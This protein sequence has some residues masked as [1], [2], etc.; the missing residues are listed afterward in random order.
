M[1]LMFFAAAVTSLDCSKLPDQEMA[2]CEAHIGERADAELN[3]LWPEVLA[4]A[5]AADKSFEPTQRRAQP[6]AAKDLLDAQRA[7]LKYRDAECASE[8]SV[9]Q[10]GSLE[11]IAV[12]QCFTDLTLARIKQLKD[13]KQAL[14][15]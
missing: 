13:T 8:A 9:Y 3:K 6:S 14:E 10:G 7:W 11:N 4:A 2:T 1:I 12:N 5:R 15:N